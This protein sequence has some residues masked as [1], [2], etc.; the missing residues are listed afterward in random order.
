MV[1]DAADI[2]AKPT[3]RKSSFQNAK[4]IILNFN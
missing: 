4:E 2:D 3:N 1:V